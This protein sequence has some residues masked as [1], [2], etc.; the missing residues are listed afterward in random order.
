MEFDTPEETIQ[1]LDIDI[2]LVSGSV[3]SATLRQDQGD[4]FH[5]A[6]TYIRINLVK[7]KEKICFYLAHVASYS[8]REREI[9]LKKAPSASQTQRPQPRVWTEDDNPLRVGDQ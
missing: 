3:R 9:R 5:I 6:E 8:I 1:V 4:S 2:E 7:P